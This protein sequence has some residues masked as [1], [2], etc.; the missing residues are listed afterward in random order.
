MGNTKVGEGGGGEEGVLVGGR[1]GV[2]EELDEKSDM[3][4]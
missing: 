1:E 4:R 3:R 2:G